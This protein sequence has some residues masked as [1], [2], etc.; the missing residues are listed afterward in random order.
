MEKFEYKVIECGDYYEP[1]KLE[2]VFN[3]LGSKGWELIL[4]YGENVTMLNFYF[5]R[6]LT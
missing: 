3:D 2:L 6:K 4:V 1:E 5:K